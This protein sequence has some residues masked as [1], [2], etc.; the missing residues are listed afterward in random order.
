MNTTRCSLFSIRIT[1]DTFF[2]LT[3]FYSH[4]FIVTEFLSLEKKPKG[5]RFDSTNLTC[6]QI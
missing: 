1:N 3:N 2:V 5:L 4:D 6:S